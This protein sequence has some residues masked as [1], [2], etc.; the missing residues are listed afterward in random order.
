MF[1]RKLKRK[2]ESL[3]RQLGYLE[4]T[5]CGSNPHSIQ[6]DLWTLQGD[7]KLLL[8]YLGLERTETHEVV[9]RKRKAQP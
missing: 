9:L 7:I 4:D 2:V 6:H 3:E 1:N 5:V 8:D